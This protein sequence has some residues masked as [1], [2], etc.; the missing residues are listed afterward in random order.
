MDSLF[1]KFINEIQID[2]LGK[3]R[4]EG[5]HPGMMKLPGV[6]VENM[7]FPRPEGGEMEHLPEEPKL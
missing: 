7:T 1:K 2:Y 4:A 5:N 3:D 6:S